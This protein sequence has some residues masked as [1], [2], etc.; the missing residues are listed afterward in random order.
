MAKRGR[1]IKL[2]AELTEEIC[3]HIKQGN[4]AKT[5][6]ALCNIS[7]STYYDWIRRGKKA[8]S[9]KFLQFLQSIKNAEKFADA[10][11]VQLI[12]QAAEKHP[13][14][15]TAAAWLLERRNPEEWG[16]IERLELEHSGKIKQEVEVEFVDEEERLLLKQ[17]ADDL[18]RRPK[19]N[20][21]DKRVQTQTK[22]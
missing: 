18:A 22:S 3:N 20:E 14:N 7:E 9:G 11:F 13:M 6:C 19:D 2:T 15:W 4:Y 5:A 17:L 1:K 12:R 8:K 21:S 10:Y 16:N